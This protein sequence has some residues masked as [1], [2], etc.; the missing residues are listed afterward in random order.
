MKTY[1]IIDMKNLVI[2][3]SPNKKT[4][5]ANY[6]KNSNLDGTYTVIATVGH[7]INL[8]H[9]H[10]AVDIMNNYKPTWVPM[11]DK[12]KVISDMKAKIKSADH[13]YLATDPDLAGEFIAWS[14][15]HLCKLSATKYNRVTFNS[16]TKPAILKG[17]E[18]TAQSNRKIDMNKVYAE[19]TRRL[20][21]RLIGFSLSPLVMKAVSGRSAGRCQSPITRLV[22]ERDQEIAKFVP[23]EQFPVVADFEYE[24]QI[25]STKL[26]KM[27]KKEETLVKFLDTIKDKTFRITDVTKTSHVKKPQLPY[28]TRTLLTD[29]SGKTG[30]SVGNIT[31]TIQSLFN[32]GHITYIRTDSTSI[33]PAMFPMLENTV[34]SLFNTSDIDKTKRHS[35]AMKESTKK[36]NSEQQGH[37]CIRVTDPGLDFN[38]I[39]NVTQRKIYIWI[40]KRT[41]ASLMKPQQYDKY[42]VKINIKGVVSHFFT[43]SIDEVM[44]DGYMKIYNEYDILGS[45]VKQPKVKNKLVEILKT[46]TGGE[47][48][49]NV[50]YRDIT[51]IQQYTNP[52]AHFSEASLL[53]KMDELKIG[54]PS[55][56]RSICDTIVQRKYVEVYSHIGV[57]KKLK[58]YTVVGGVCTETSDK[59]VIGAVK[60][61]MK[62]TPLGENVVNYLC[63]DF[64]DIMDYK[65]TSNLEQDI[66]KVEEGTS[67][68]TDVVDKFYK[69]FSP[70]VEE[71][72]KKF[73]DDPNHH[74]RHL[75][76][77]LGK[78]VFAY[79]SKYDPVVQHGAKKPV[80]AK[81]PDGKWKSITLEEAIELIK[82]ADNT[83]RD[84]NKDKQSIK[85]DKK[86]Y[87][88]SVA[89]GRFGPYISLVLVGG[90]KKDKAIF[91]S[92]KKFLKDDEAYTS[93]SQTRINTI[94]DEYCKEMKRT[95]FK[96]YKD[97]GVQ[98]KKKRSYYIHLTN[99]KKKA[100]PIF[101]SIPKE[102]D[103]MTI[104]Q[105]QVTE[106]V[107]KKMES[108]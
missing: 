83:K 96:D 101:V 57:E 8:D 25:I 62:T 97:Y 42:S 48:K 56:Y 28:K 47:L 93:L 81:I 71:S 65:Y 7:I 103:A 49:I 15:F 98:V 66:I 13:V 3:E 60:N 59:K 88:V 26:N 79:K 16:I 12:K 37:E 76:K 5:I 85:Y 40:W 54:R 21:D 24:K 20:L 89:D 77:Y 53:S 46:M 35:L 69:A 50:S 10:M 32:Q 29:I 43:G 108:S 104:T 74:K 61:K 19:Q 72:N 34:S 92:L 94:C 90:T 63:K 67:D 23:D 45:K 73:K 82:N 51:A 17:F 105:D 4:K 30:M 22:Y 6:L 99:K 100:K 9:G 68:W 55:T 36:G 38:E 18:V 14:V 33:D 70:T 75:G 64:M 41:L 52:P 106:L 11:S 80:Y 91:I 102:I 31:N 44:Y 95:T 107:K 78:D 39:D 86:D 87:Y 27:F 58:K 2:I 1:Y 84:V